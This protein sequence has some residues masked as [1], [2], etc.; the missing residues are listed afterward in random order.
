MQLYIKSSNGEYHE[1]QESDIASWLSPRLE[2]V[3]KDT[4][5]KTT[6]E[7][8]E[9]L[10]DELTKSLTQELTDKL[11][12]DITKTVEE[13]YKPKL[14]EVQNKLTAAETQIRQKTIAAEYGFKPELESF[15][16]EGT[17]DDM[18]AKADILKESNSTGTPPNKSTDDKVSSTQKS[19]GV[20]VEI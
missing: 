20:I 5:D 10:K 15:L 8:K 4:A 3:R 7:V 1:T 16:G 19:T 18:R 9:K 6:A 14:N 17:D 12:K 2:K 11:T 13:E